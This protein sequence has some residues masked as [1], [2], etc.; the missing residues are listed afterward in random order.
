MYRKHFAFTRF[1][2][3]TERDPD[4]LF[5]SSA[6]SEAHVRLNHLL[7]LRG[8]GLV[9]GEV[10]SGKTT[11]CRKVAS[12]LHPGLYRPFYV[13]LSTGHVMDMYKS[14][15][16]GHCGRTLSSRHKIHPLIAGEIT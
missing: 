16:S 11:I 1:P 2:F 6:L 10:G 14:H 12:A 5:A 3:E 7:E 8:I 13:P 4:A 15:R 9:T